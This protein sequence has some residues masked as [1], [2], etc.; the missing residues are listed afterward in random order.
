MEADVLGGWKS[1]VILRMTDG[2]NQSA[3][4]LAPEPADPPELND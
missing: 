4:G 1:G 3:V 2:V